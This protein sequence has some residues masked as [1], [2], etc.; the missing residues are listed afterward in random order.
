MWRAALLRALHVWFLLPSVTHVIVRGTAHSMTTNIA[1]TRNESLISGTLVLNFLII[2]RIPFGNSPENPL[3]PRNWMHLLFVLDEDAVQL[4]EKPSSY[5]LYRRKEELGACESQ[6]ETDE[7]HRWTMEIRVKQQASV[8]PWRAHCNASHSFAVIFMKI[9][10]CFSSSLPS[11]IRK[12]HKF[13]SANLPLSVHPPD[14]GYPCQYS[15]EP[16]S[17]ISK[18]NKCLEIFTR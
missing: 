9:F 14:V 12:D 8:P 15:P 5:S 10:F 1:C 18:I 16:S 2:F 3:H 6:E 4:I 17:Y 13:A 7:V 11:S